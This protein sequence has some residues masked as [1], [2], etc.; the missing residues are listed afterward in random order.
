MIDT[1]ANKSTTFWDRAGSVRIRIRVNLDSRIR[2]MDNLRLRLDALAEVNIT[3]KFTS[4]EAIGDRPH[5]RHPV[6][7]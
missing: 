7:Q 1:Q 6:G 4:L 3:H 5:H 2:I